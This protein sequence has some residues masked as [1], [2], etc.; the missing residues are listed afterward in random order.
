MVRISFSIF[1]FLGEEIVGKE[2]QLGPHSSRDIEVGRSM[3]EREEVRRKESCSCLLMGFEPNL[4][5]KK[6]KS[7]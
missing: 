2:G 6:H 1:P 7:H 3:D 4:D 5:G